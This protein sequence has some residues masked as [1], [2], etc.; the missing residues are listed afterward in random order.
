MQIQEL[1]QLPQTMLI[2]KKMVMSSASKELMDQS[3]VSPQMMPGFLTA[4]TLVPT[5]TLT[6]FSST[7]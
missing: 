7:Q 4:L 2:A 1:T 5:S 6:K 3:H